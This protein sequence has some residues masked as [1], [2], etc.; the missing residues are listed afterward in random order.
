[1]LSLAITL[2]VGERKPSD[3]FAV[4]PA[5]AQLR[6]KRIHTFAATACPRR[7]HTPGCLPPDLNPTLPSLPLLQLVFTEVALGAVVLTINV[8]LLG[9][10]IVFFQ[11]LCLIGYC[12]FPIVLAAIICTLV[13][14]SVSQLDEGLR[15]QI[16]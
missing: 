9:G 4:S 6:L 10:N 13:K 15:Q 3:V 12:L 14:I 5:A 11:S 1:M 2:S 7:R 16:T 8:I